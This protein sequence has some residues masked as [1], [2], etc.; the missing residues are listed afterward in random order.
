MK[1]QMLRCL[2]ERNSMRSIGRIFQ[3]SIGW[4]Y[5]FMIEHWHEISDINLQI[6]PEMKS[7]D[8]DFEVDELCTYVKKKKTKV[9]IWI[10]YHRKTKQ[11][12]AF[13]MGD[14][15]AKTCKKLWRKLQELGIKGKIHTDLWKAYANIFPPE[16]HVPHDQR[17]STNHIERFN[18]TLRARVSRLVRRTYSIAK[19]FQ[20][21]FLSVR[22][23]IADYNKSLI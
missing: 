6:T 19:S 11:I 10:V 9:W 20:N 3:V 15:S 12:V 22:F 16:Q 21:L 23:F 13:Q 18:G 17:G 4:F 8:A 2:S 5:R 1:E 7:K 14:R